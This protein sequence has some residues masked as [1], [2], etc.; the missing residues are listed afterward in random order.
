MGKGRNGATRREPHGEQVLIAKRPAGTDAPAP[1]CDTDEPVG[2]K[3]PLFRLTVERTDGADANMPVRWCLSKEALAK[4][5]GREAHDPHL[6]VVVARE[7]P[8]AELGHRLEELE[9]MLLPLDRGMDRVMFPRAGA[10]RVYAMV[11]WATD[12][13]TD[14]ARWTSL[15]ACFLEKVGGGYRSRLINGEEFIG[16][17]EFPWGIKCLDHVAELRVLVD[18]RFFAKK[19]PAWLAWYVNLWCN[20]KPRD[21]CQFRNR[22]LWAF[23]IKWLPMLLWCLFQGIV[24]TVC[25]LTLALIGRRYIALSPIWHPFAMILSEVDGDQKYRLRDSRGY[26][27]Q[28]T[29]DEKPRSTLFF[30]SATPL[31]WVAYAAMA[32]FAWRRWGGIGPWDVGPAFFMVFLAVIAGTCVALMLSVALIRDSIRGRYNAREASRREHE[33]SALAAVEAEKNRHA[34][35]AF[36]RYYQRRLEPLTCPETEKMVGVTRPKVTVDALP[37]THRTLHL[38][39]MELKARVC[40]PFAQ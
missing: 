36:I 37:P 23:G 3:P 26:W 11:V 19:P 20:G 18:A 31:F 10:Y 40:R 2:G 9:H 24:R 17:K 12:M 22:F 27:T 5:Q 25:A 13:S 32:W 29:R 16:G 39:F 4:L 28:V 33:R 15:Y 6:L 8:D 34:H 30:L 38:R 35:E 1:G 7:N 21:E 14:T